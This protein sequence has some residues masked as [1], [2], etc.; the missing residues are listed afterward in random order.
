LCRILPGVGR[1]WPA[2]VQP[3]PL[4]R[5]GLL[6]PP[7]AGRSP[8]ILRG[9]HNMLRCP[10]GQTA[11]GLLLQV[12]LLPKPTAAPSASNQIGGKR[13]S[14]SKNASSSPLTCAL[15]PVQAWL[16]RRQYG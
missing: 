6:S 3:F 16:W 10:I 12:F 15:A 9:G 4:N 2:I 7:H 5:R 13:G 14:T 1:H 8:E 11:A